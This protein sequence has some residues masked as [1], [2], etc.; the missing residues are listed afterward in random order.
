LDE[1]SGRY[2]A[3]SKMVRGTRRDAEAELRRILRSRDTGEYVAPSKLRVGDF[4]DRWLNTVESKVSK[5][6]SS[7]YRYML[8]RYARPI[9][10]PRRLQRL[11]PLDVQE[12]ISELNEKRLSPRTVQM[13]HRILKQALKQAVVWRLL[14]VNPAEGVELPRGRRQER[15]ALSQKEVKAFREAARKDRWAVLFDFALATGMRPSEYCG[16]RWQD[17]DLEKG[18]A[19]VNQVLARR[20]GAWEFTVPK[21]KRSR[22]TIPL[23]AELIAALREHRRAQAAQALRKGPAYARAFDLVFAT[24][25]GQPLSDRNLVQRHFKR[26][27]EEAKLPDSIRLYDLRHTTCTLMLAAGLQVKVVS[28]RL[29]HSSAA[30]TLDVYG[31]VLPGQQE[32]ATA[33]LGELL[34]R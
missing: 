8:D 2:R 7:D 18:L 21:T 24:P 19:S 31:H 34:F 32:E 3:K 20:R 25:V 5:R 16:L 30:M 33:T 1:A 17:V 14:V 27:L 13:A 10:G 12:M 9:I 11:S 4:L 6:T 26:I 29:G 23:P 15:R 28:E 22:R